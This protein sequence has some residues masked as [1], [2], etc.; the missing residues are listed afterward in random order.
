[1]AAIHL[2]ELPFYNLL[3]NEFCREFASNRWNAVFEYSEFGDY[4]RKLNSG[5]VLRDLNF[6]YSTPEE[7]NSS[8]CKTGSNICFSVFHLN[9]RSLN[10]KHALLCQLLSLIELEFDVIVLSE[11]WTVNIQFLANIFPGYSFYCDLPSDSKIGGVGLFVK[12]TL[13]HQ[14]ISHLKITSTSNNRV[15][16]MWV[17]I[18]CGKM[19]Y[20]VGGIYRH[21]NQSI[22]DFISSM[23]PVLNEIT[24]QKLPCFIAG[25]IN[26]DLTK[27]N[28]SCDTAAYVDLLLMHNC[29]P[30]IL[31]PTRVTSRSAT[32]IDHIYYYEGMNRASTPLVDS[33][34]LLTDI[35]DHMPNY[36]LVWDKKSQINSPRPFVRIFSENN[37]RN[38]LN[39]LS[40]VNWNSVCNEQDA[41]GAYDNFINIVNHAFENSFK[42]TRLS[43]KRSK[44]KRWITGAL[45]RSSKVKNKLYRKWMF[46]RSMVDEVA[47]KKYRATFRKA[48]AEA[49]TLYY[50]EMFNSRTNSIKKLWENLNTVCA[51][52]KKN[53]SNSISQLR[54]GTG[55]VSTSDEICAEFNHYFSTIGSVLLDDLNK[56]HP[57]ATDTDFIQYCDKSTKT[58]M[59]VTP[60][61]PEELQRLVC[62]L[63]NNKSPG[64]DNIGPSLVKLIFPAICFPLL[65]IYNLSL[66]TGVV[67]RQLKIAKVIPV[68]KK[69]DVDLICNYRP[70]SLLSIFDKLLEKIMAKRLSL[71]LDTNNIL[72]KFQFGF[73]RN[74]STSL[75]LVDVIDNILEDLDNHKHV[76]GTYLDL[77]KAFDTVNHRILLHKLYNYGIRGIAYEWFCSYLSDRYQFTCVNNSKSDVNMI[78]CGV[79]QGSVLGPLLFL[80]YVNDIANAVPNVNVKLFADDTNLFV[81]GPSLVSVNLTA[82]DS[83]NCLN[84]WFIANKLSLN[85]DKTC[86]MVF[87]SDTNNNTRLTVDTQ[88]IQK[89]SSCR[90]LGV[91]VDDELKWINHIQHIYNKLLKYTSIFYK[92]RTKVP[93]R[94][95]FN[96][97]Y[98]FVHPH[99]LYA[100]EVYGN[101]CSSYI[102]KLSKLNNKLL[103]ILQY[104]SFQ[105]HAPDLY[106]EFNTLPITLLHEQQ[107][108]ILAHK[109]VHHPLSVP[110]L[111]IDYLN[112]NESVHTHN[113]RNKNNMHLPRAN[114]GY[115]LKCLKYKIPKLWNDLP[116]DLKEQSSIYTFKKELKMYLIT[117]LYNDN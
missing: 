46:T 88:E 26:I 32:L 19:K 6:K 13:N 99:L 93:S 25:D 98:A 59:F 90:Y 107:V 57:S 72:H 77:Q 111:F 97:Y 68:Y 40:T 73:R 21:P 34:N 79:P 36:M 47:Y 12:N 110:E 30:T 103:R 104:K 48:A 14:E 51:F 112:T 38:F 106:F 94:I 39:S 109:I 15:E 85:I 9:V 33:G 29:L 16:N 65:H 22:R 43:R 89:V 67:P 69:G 92:L 8:V 81:A 115:G 2:S 28:S 49:E 66:S 87:P 58:S 20:I 44:D 45:K 95:L 7:L 54:C 1:M 10:S 18:Q 86:Y 50:R 64:M 37:K 71:H 55:I 108:L 75:A 100:I 27:Y 105:S 70:I 114:T 102:D 61:G 80:I 101:T 35:S 42:P 53:T 78:T 63:N 24:E 84:Q 82:I 56:R 5:S 113:T 91:I 83:I 76:I 17:E 4:I 31:M 74:H 41:T 96:I 117:K 116:K 3:D 52:K 23:E 60:V 62:R 11:I